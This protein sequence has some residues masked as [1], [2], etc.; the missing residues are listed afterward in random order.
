MVFHKNLC[1]AGLLWRS[2]SRLTGF[3]KHG[4]LSKT[5]N[6][7]FTN[8]ANGANFYGFIRNIRSFATFALK[9]LDFENAIQDSL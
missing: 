6:A 3:E 2:Q 7:N 1:F 9:I 8:G 4:A 5:L